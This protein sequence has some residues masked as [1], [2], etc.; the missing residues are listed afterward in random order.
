[1]DPETQRNDQITQ[2]SDILRILSVET[3]LRMLL[4][5]TERNLCVGAL[6]CRL[7]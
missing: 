7:R 2:V 1:M 6:A 3:R 5:L 4:L